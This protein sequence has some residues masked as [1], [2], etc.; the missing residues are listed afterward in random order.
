MYETPPGALGG[1]D[2]SLVDNP[3]AA[4]S[5]TQRVDGDVERRHG[6]PVDVLV[7]IVEAEDVLTFPVEPVLALAEGGYAVE[8]RE[9]ATTRLVGVELGTFAHGFVEITGDGVEGDEVVVQ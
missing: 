2:L 3:S 9:G 6:S 7:T 4:S 8:V 1:S 5:R